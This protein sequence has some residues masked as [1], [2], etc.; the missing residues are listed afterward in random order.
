LGGCPEKSPLDRFSPE[1]QA[2]VKA[3][4][5]VYQHGQSVGMDGKTTGHGESHVLINKRASECFRVF[6][7][8]DK[9]Q[10]YF[11]RKKASEVVKAWDDKALVHKV[12]DFYVVEVEYAVLCAIDSKN[13]RVD[14]QLDTKY[15]HDI[16]D[17]AGYFLF[18][19]VDD[20]T[21]LFTYAATKVQT[22]LKVPF[23]IQNYLTSRDLPDVVA[24]VKMRIESG[25]TW[26][27]DK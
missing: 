16:E 14:F 6:L 27:K 13:R 18:E 12:F 23:S 4:E 5:A 20:K 10:L 7:E 26:T 17:T 1:Q 8:F 15:K 22:G 3:G 9:H 2:K 11:P 25:G 21:T 24:N 19:P